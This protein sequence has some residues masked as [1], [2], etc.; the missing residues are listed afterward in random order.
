MADPITGRISHQKFARAK[1]YALQR[2]ERELPAHLVYHNLWH[3]CDDV[4][5]AAVRLARIIGANE[6]DTRLLLTAV[7]FHDIGFIIQAENHEMT[8]AQTAMLVLPE[9]GYTK[10][11]VKAVADMILATRLPQ[12]PLN[13]MAEIVADADLDV[14]GREDY[15]IRNR[16]LRAELAALGRV[17]IDEGWYGAQLKFIQVHHYFT[18]AARNLRDSQKQANVQSMQRLLQESQ[19]YQLDPPD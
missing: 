9:I 7:Y 15:L 12:H 19:F 1:D 5:P 4:A 8:S 10:K 11:Q 6:E 2:L 3:T 14:L 17:F 13:W 16:A 18:A